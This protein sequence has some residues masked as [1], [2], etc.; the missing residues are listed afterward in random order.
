[1]APW[2]QHVMKCLGYRTTEMKGQ[3]RTGPPCVW[4]HPKP[5]Y[6]SE[7]FISNI[8][9]DMFEDEL[10]PMLMTV[11]ALYELRLMKTFSGEGT[12]FAFARYACSEAAKIAV[13]CLNG[14]PLRSSGRL[15]AHVCVNNRWIRI[16]CPPISPWTSLCVFW[17][18]I[19]N[20]VTCVT[21]VKG[22]GSSGYAFVQ[23]ESHQ[24]AS[25]AIKIL[26][27]PHFK[28]SGIKVSWARPNDVFM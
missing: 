5:G 9:C 16:F 13:K 12:G 6:G 22:L 20:V 17:Y 4:N 26:I 19:Q 1:M 14:M 15:I 8:P 28:E 18:I 3:R 11:G 10:L 25:Q 24:A 27:Q 21:N 23:F 2:L 7:I